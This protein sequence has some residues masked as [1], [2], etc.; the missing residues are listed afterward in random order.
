MIIEK[1]VTFHHIPGCAV[2]ASTVIKGVFSLIFKLTKQDSGTKTA[3]IT[4]KLAPFLISFFVQNIF[5]V[6][7]VGNKF[8]IFITCDDI[9]FA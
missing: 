7:K 8:S 6:G 1:S 5:V 9:K 4:I 2:H 3:S